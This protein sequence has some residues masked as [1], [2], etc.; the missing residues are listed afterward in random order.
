MD[1]VT[2][3]VGNVSHLVCKRCGYYKYDVKLCKTHEWISGGMDS[4][5]CDTC[6]LESTVYGEHCWYSLADRQIVK[7]YY[8][9]KLDN[10]ES[11]KLLRGRN[12]LIMQKGG[13]WREGDKVGA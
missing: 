6:G 12:C 8:N 2:V 1:K 9:N 3:D 11:V 10:N 5:Y 7:Q 4:S 13:V